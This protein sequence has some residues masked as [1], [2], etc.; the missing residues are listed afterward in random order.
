MLSRRSRVSMFVVQLSHAHAVS[1]R[2]HA[3]LR[4]QELALAL[5][6]LAA[7]RPCER[8]LTL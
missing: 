7:V 5:P 3:T 8:P 4:L 6:A 1:R 2:G